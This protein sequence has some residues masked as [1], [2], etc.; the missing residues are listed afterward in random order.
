MSF[1]VIRYAQRFSVRRLALFALAVLL[2]AL[3]AYVISGIA[4]IYNSGGPVGIHQRNVTRELTEWKQTYGKVSSHHEAI[5]TAEMLEYVQ[6]YYVPAEGYRSTPEIE[7]A[8][9]IQRRETTDTF[10]EVLRDYTGKDFG[11]DSAQW[12]NYLHGQSTE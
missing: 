12:L 10:I 2:T 6:S 7:A 3:V 8:Q 11:T 5:R 1:D 9:Q 4:Y